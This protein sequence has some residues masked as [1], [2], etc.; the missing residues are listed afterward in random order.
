MLS[1]STMT[2][3]PKPFPDD[4]KRVIQSTLSVFETGKP[5]GDYTVASVLD[6]GAGLTYGFHQSTR[7]S[8]YAIVNR[9]VDRR[10]DLADDLS[11]YLARLKNEDSRQADPANLPDWIVDLIDLLTEA[12]HDPIMQT[13]QDEVFDELYW[14]P[15]VKLARNMGLVHPLSFLV[16]Y[17]TCIHSGP[18]GVKRIRKL[19]P[20]RPP[21]DGGDE[22]SWVRGYLKARRGW[23]AG[24]S[25]PVVQK[26]VNRI[27]VMLALVKAGNWALL[28]P[29]DIGRPYNVT[30]SGP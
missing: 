9:Y 20:T 23:L 17:D 2:T 14:D 25:N 3:G 16:V 22:R 30:V 18:G 8:L 11:T 12:G 21:A 1:M 15:A 26:T 6:D 5:E 19:F 13:V 10:G 7:K 27:D 28:T 4:K 24:H 29:F